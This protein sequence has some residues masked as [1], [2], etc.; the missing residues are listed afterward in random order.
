MGFCCG[1]GP[2]IHPLLLLSLVGPEVVRHARVPGP[3]LAGVPWTKPTGP[4]VTSS[5]ATA[6]EGDDIDDRSLSWSL[7]PRV[8]AS[9]LPSLSFLRATVRCSTSEAPGLEMAELLRDTFEVRLVR[10]SL[11]GRH[12]HQQS[13]QPSEFSGV[14]HS[15]QVL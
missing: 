12:R 6:A 15:E 2:C 5:L 10:Q 11:W 7:E 9:F 4:G 3:V 1:S 13:Q 14:V 8:R